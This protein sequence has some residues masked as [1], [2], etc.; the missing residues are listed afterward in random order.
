[1]VWIL[2]KIPI[3]VESFQFKCEK[4]EIT[5]KTVLNVV[6]I[7]SLSYVKY[8][9]TRIILWNNTFSPVFVFFFCTSPQP[10][11]SARLDFCTLARGPGMWYFI[12]CLCKM[13][14]K[15]EGGFLIVSNRWCLTNR[16]NEVL[17]LWKIMRM[18]QIW[19]TEWP[20]LKMVWIWFGIKNQYSCS[21]YPHICSFH[22]IFSLSYSVG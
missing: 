17:R 7:E 2:I 3:K 5:I 15:I 18:D 8:L 9:L 20:Q 16:E 1:M 11:G 6:I 4:T 14:A 19:K 22:F 21:R 12:V 13:W 10:N